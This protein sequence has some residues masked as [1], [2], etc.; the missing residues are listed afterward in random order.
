M[1]RLNSGF[2]LIELLIALALSLIVVL[3]VAQVFIAAKNTYVSQNTAASM[4]EDARF[5]LSKMI[6]EIRMVGMF[7]CL[8]TIT[9]ASST[10]DFNANQITPI[11]WD[12]ANL[13][14]TLVS[15]DVGSSGGVPTWTVVSDCRNTATAYTGV[16][17]SASGQQAFPIRRLIYSLKNGQLT[18]G[19][20]SGTPTQFVLVDNVS[21]F[22][23]SFGLASSTTD[24]AA[25]S[26]SANPADPARIRS[27]RLTLTLTD[28]NNRVRNQTFNVVAALRN[29]L[30]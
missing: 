22:N 27:V 13:K 24:T 19:V 20:G 25:S 16:R 1:K 28:P 10:G 18:M 7:G 9:D 30:P 26:Y 17:V 6:Q 4:Q 15:A 11:N 8:G 21:A 3:G 29:R 2:G 12:N 23:V 14:L 5:V